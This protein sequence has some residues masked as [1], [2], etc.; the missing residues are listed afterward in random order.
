MTFCYSTIATSTYSLFFSSRR[1]HTRWPR[2]W[3]SDVCS[4]DLDHAFRQDP[5]H[6]RYDTREI[7]VAAAEIPGAVQ[8]GLEER[9]RTC[10]SR[11]VGEVGVG[12]IEPSRLPQREPIQRGG[13]LRRSGAFLV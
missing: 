9:D 4:S 6:Q 10:I 7:G 5:D 13:Q 12:G 3:S 1:R 2:D 11:L 8:I